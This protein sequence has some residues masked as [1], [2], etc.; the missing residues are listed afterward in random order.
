[1]NLDEIKEAVDA[2]KTVCWSNDGYEVRHSHDDE[3]CPFTLEY[4][5]VD[6]YDIVFVSTGYTIGLTWT[7]EITLNGKEKDFYIKGER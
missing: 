5:P 3:L 1:M 2:G 4:T 6:S 7:D